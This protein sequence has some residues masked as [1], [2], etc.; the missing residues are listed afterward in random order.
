[1]KHLFLHQ[2]FAQWPTLWWLLIGQNT[3]KAGFPELIR[4]HFSL[5]TKFSLFYPF[6]QI[7]DLQKYNTYDL[8]FVKQAIT[9][10][11][12]LINWRTWWL[13]RSF[14]GF[15]VVEYIVLSH[16]YFFVS[17]YLSFS[18]PPWYHILIEYAGFNILAQTIP[19]ILTGILHI[20]EKKLS[21]LY[22]TDFPHYT[23][24]ICPHE[25]IQY[26]MQESTCGASQ[27]KYKWKCSQKERNIQHHQRRLEWKGNQNDKRILA[28]RD[29]IG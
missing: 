26:E 21:N 24:Q 25:Y 10:I 19:H 6:A 29:K 16:L 3:Q 15:Y 5:N 14:N 7:Q 8:S 1:M 27:R 12:K 23:G 13:S 2:Y 22:R 28:A 20:I 17:L 9:K 18:L 4:G 11:L